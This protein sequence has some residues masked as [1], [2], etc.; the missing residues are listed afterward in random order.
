MSIKHGENALMKS[1]LK[2]QKYEFKNQAKKPAVLPTS[3]VN[4]NQVI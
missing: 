2:Y 4:I 3:I 1:K